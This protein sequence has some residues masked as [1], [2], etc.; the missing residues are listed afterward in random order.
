MEYLSRLKRPRLA[1]FIESGLARLPADWQDYVA[2]GPKESQCLFCDSE[3]E[4]NEVLVVKTDLF[5]KN[6]SMIDAYSCYDCFHHLRLK[7][8][9]VFDGVAG[10]KASHYNSKITEER[11]RL[12]VE[13]YHFHFDH[14]MYLQEFEYND[15]GIPTKSRHCYFCNTVVEE[16]DYRV[17]DVPVDNGVVLSGGQLR[18]CRGCW[19]MLKLELPEYTL[20]SLREKHRLVP[21]YCRCGERYYLTPSEHADREV[22]R[23]TGMHLCPKCTF[24][25]LNHDPFVLDVVLTT[26]TN[27]VDQDEDPVGKHQKY[28]I[29]RFVEVLCE[30][31]QDNDIDI[32]LTV[33][34]DHLQDS[35]L[36]GPKNKICCSSCSHNGSG[37]LVVLRYNRFIWR[38]YSNGPS[39]EFI[40][41]I[42]TSSGTPVQTKLFTG[43]LSDAVVNY[44][45]DIVE[46]GKTMIPLI[47]M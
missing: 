26:E 7:E 6:G 3:H 47:N 30:Y 14:A 22:G 38:I 24:A 11:M 34:T 31:C 46:T 18:C 16:E 45:V 27:L 20:T 29:N 4:N 28:A 21:E 35:L 17:I 10:V 1:K 19:E 25:Q 12:F 9:E 41:V 36:L 32:D 5:Q 2:G 33:H 23:T 43:P 40:I 39:N 44:R 15:L 42:K 8:A 13:E 37:P